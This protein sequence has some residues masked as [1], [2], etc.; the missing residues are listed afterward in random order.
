MDFK[1]WI[2]HFKK[3]SIPLMSNQS[4]IFQKKRKSSREFR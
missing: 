2:S 3:K 1:I 4:F